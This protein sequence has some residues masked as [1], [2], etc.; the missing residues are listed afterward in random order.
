[1]SRI[2][3]WRDFAAVPL[4]AAAIA[5]FTGAFLIIESTDDVD[6]RAGAAVLLVLGA[7]A[8]GAWVYA[9][10]SSRYTGHSNTGTLSTKEDDDGGG[11]DG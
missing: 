5:C 10:G 2:R 8:F 1:M 3:P 9:L 6:N 11:G 4:A 7:V